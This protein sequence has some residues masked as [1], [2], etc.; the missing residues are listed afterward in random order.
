MG[1]ESGNFRERLGVTEENYIA[2]LE[3]RKLE[4]KSPD[5]PQMRVREAQKAGSC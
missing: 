1:A 3:R 4:E 5:G 2:S